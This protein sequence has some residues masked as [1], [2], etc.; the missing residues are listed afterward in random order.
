MPVGQARLKRLI[1]DASVVCEVGLAACHELHQRQFFG[2]TP[3]ERVQDAHDTRRAG[4][5]GNQLYLPNPLATI[6]PV[7]LEDTRAGGL[8]PWRERGGEFGRRAVEVGVCA[9]SK[10]FGAVQDFFDAH[11][12]DH[13]GMRANPRPPQR[14]ITQ[15]RV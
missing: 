4:W 3:A 14:H 12:E 2:Q 15:Q 8:Q 6:A 1:D 9:P 7:L 13:V 10:M 5:L 11:F